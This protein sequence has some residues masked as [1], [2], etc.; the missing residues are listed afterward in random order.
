MSNPRTNLNK[1]IK[2][3]NK[4]ETKLVAIFCKYYISFLKEIYTKSL[5]EFQEK[6]FKIPNWSD[7]KL[8]KEFKYFL[9]YTN[10][11]YNL[12]EDEL[13]KILDIIFSLYLDIDSFKSIEITVPK[14][15]SFWYNCLKKIAKYF[16]ENPTLIKQDELDKNIFTTIIKHTIQKYIPFNTLINPIKYTTDKYDFENEW[17]KSQS[18]SSKSSKSNKSNYNGKNENQN[19]LTHISSDKFENEYYHSE[20]EKIENKP[21]QSASNQ[22]KQIKLPKYMFS[23]KH[24]YNQAKLKKNDEINEH[25]FNK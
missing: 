13:S 17:T 7:E 16:Y 14:T 9:N 22:E 24:N 3:K 2:I 19:S 1:S 25:F 18:K 23:K 4:Y 10:K 6:L 5:R 20:E 11:K 8:H 15:Q 21:E 12:D